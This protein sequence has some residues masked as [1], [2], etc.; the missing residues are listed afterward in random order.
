MSD[1]CAHC[2]LRGDIP[3]CEEQPCLIQESWYAAELH[4]R[5]DAALDAIRYAMPGACHESCQHSGDAEDPTWHCCDWAMA[6]V[7]F[8]AVLALCVEGKP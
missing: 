2:V 1:Q 5:L 3:A 7:K 6:V 4:K 8:R